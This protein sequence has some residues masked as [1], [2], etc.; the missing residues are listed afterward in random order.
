MTFRD[1]ICDLEHYINGNVLPIIRCKMAGHPG[2]TNTSP[3]SIQDISELLLNNGYLP[4]THA[5][6]AFHDVIVDY[7]IDYSYKQELVKFVHHQEVRVVPPVPPLVPMSPLVPTFTGTD[8][9]SNIEELQCPICMDNKKSVCATECGHALCRKCFTA[10][11]T[12][13]SCCPV[14]RR[15]ITSYNQIWL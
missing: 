10:V 6:K 12:G 15:A 5:F 4:G 2:W 7:I 3:A 8:V 9:P 13:P 11:L 1:T 14:C